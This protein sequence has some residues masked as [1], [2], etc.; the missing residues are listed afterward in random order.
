M[1]RIPPL[2][3]ANQQS[4]GAFA[5]RVKSSFTS[6]LSVMYSEWATYFSVQVSTNDVRKTLSALRE[7]W[8]KI[9]PD[10]A[11]NY[12]FIDERFDQQYM[13]DVKF[14]QVM[15]TFSTLAIFIAC[16]GLFGLS[17]YMIVQRTKEISI[18]KVLGA[19]VAQI[20][21][22]LSKDFAKVV[23][24][25]AL[26]AIPFSWYAMNEWLSNYSTRIELSAW[27]FVVPVGVI[28][29]IA[30]GTVSL[31]TFKSALENPTNS[32]KQEQ[33]EF[34]RKTRKGTELSKLNSFVPCFSMRNNIS[35]NKTYL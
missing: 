9:F 18:R 31:Q 3:L 33:I 29:L 5:G 35:Q 32:L 8:A 6:R 12:F 19:S 13:A 2:E 22:L 27:L 34:S 25:A 15:A 11:F 24:I 4:S 7:S 17:S 21:G 23:F 14:G 26:L 16:L 1:C 30:M 28:L 10:N 20:V